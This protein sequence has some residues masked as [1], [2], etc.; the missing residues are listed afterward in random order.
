MKNKKLNLFITS[1]DVNSFVKSISISK[2]Y[3]Y[4]IISFSFIVLFFSFFGFYYIFF[5]KINVEISKINNKP[6]VSNPQDSFL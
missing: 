5:N 3:I 4:F 1:N 2:Y 6:N